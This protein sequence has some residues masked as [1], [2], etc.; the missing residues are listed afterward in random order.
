M[1]ADSSEFS[2]STDSSEDSLDDEDEATPAQRFAVDIVALTRE[3]G[4]ADS[5][6]SEDSSPECQGRHTR[7]RNM[8][9][10]LE[11]AERRLSTRSQLILTP[12]CFENPRVQAFASVIIFL[13]TNART[14]VNAAVVDHYI[15][16]SGG[17]R[18]FALCCPYMHIRPT[19]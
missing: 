11:A 14:M 19:G 18:Q 15:N 5:E 10:A 4:H 9:L 3:W 8:A 7:Y 13:T 6:I 17:Q 1:S 12:V 2:F 16:K